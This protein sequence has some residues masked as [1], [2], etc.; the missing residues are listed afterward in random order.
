VEQTCPKISAKLRHF[1]GIRA[2]NRIE[3]PP[4]I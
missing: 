3:C 4:K 2:N 1:F